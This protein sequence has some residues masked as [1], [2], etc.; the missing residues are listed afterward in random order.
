M[1]RVSP[2]RSRYAAITSRPELHA[3]AFHVFHP[4]ALD[5]QQRRRSRLDDEEAWCDLFPLLVVA[6]SGRHI[7]QHAQ[8]GH[9]HGWFGAA[10]APDL[11]ARQLEVLD[12]VAVGTTA[13]PTPWS[14]SWNVAPS[15]QST[16]RVRRSAM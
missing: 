1:E 8:Q 3:P 7:P 13:R 15:R 16:R 4:S 5:R 12:E 14:S 6:R 9:Q 2:A 10:E 11:T